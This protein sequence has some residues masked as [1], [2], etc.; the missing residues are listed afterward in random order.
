MIIYVEC[1]AIGIIKVSEIKLHV[2]D[3]YVTFIVLEPE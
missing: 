2:H 1:L 3:D